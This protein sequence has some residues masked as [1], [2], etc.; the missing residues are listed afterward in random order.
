[1]CA[2]L[3]VP[4]PAL[5]QPQPGKISNDV[6]KIGVLTDM[7][8]QFSHEAGEGSVTAVKMAVEDFGGK[9]LGRPIEVIV[10]DH[11]N[12]T[13]IAIAKAKEWFD[14]DH[15]DMIANLINSA[16]AIGVAG[17][18]REKNGIAIVN[19]SGS[20]R[21]TGDACTPNS[22]HYAYDTYAL[23][24]GTGNELIRQGKKRWFFLTADYAFGHALEAD[25]AT[26]VKAGG[27]EVVGA[28]RY[29]INTLDHGSFMLQ[30]QGSKADVVAVA[31]SGT[32]FINAVK[33]ARDF[34]LTQSGKQVLA[35]LLVW[36]TDIHAMGLQA[37]QGLVLTNAFYW[38]RDEETR[39]FSKKFE[40]RMGRKPH[41]GD[42]GDYS[43]TMHYLKAVQAAG[44]DEAQAVMAKM[45]ELKVNDFFAKGGTI[46]ADGRFIHDMYVYQVKT[47]AESKGP[48]DY[49]K[50][51]SVIP[52]EKAFRPLSESACPLV[53]KP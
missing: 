27:G 2:A 37:A 31:G 48:W 13:E 44:T 21:L 22:I 16:V 39:A 32:V 15:V 42:A 14:V 3:A 20:S 33:A 10:A 46:R 51:V 53:K 28:V 26:V 35:G 18:A 34:G 50:L 45:R 49:Y 47:P 43:S 6:V 1:M 23:A 11:Q 40:A 17:V 7:S 41:M 24:V 36:I 12:K 38:D 4:L 30:A 52:G 9:V 29:P 19:G 25:T 5:A 8:G